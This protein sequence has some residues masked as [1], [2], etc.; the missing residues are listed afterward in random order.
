MEYVFP[1]QGYEHINDQFLLG[2]QILVAP[3]LE[4][5]AMHRSVTLPRGTWK[6]FDGKQYLG[7][8]K[9]LIPVPFDD[10]CYFE[11]VN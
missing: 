8:A 9:I 4:K 3:V 1:H 2:N 7:P 5:G 11:K 6:G 10:L